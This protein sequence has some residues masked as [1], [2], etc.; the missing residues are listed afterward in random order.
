MKKMLILA[1][2]IFVTFGC[3]SSVDT[4]KLSVEQTVT[5]LPP[6]VHTVVHTV[7]TTREVERVVTEIVVQTMIVTAT[8]AGPTFTPTVTNTP[9]PTIDSTKTDKKP[10]TYLIGSQIAPGNW[11]SLGNGDGCYWKVSDNQ[12]EIVNNYFGSAGTIMYIP[13]SGYLVEL[14]K[15]C[16]NWQYLGK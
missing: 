4:L 8:Y 7:E 2:V 12:G 3:N 16:G 11:R 5:A 15:K 10:G 14:E 6:I 9:E 1:M 13:P